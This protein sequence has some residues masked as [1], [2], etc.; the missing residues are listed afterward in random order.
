MTLEN[1]ILNDLAISQ[2]TASALASR[3]EKKISTVETQLIRMEKEGTVRRKPI[4]DG[5]LI[6]WQLA[7]AQ[8]EVI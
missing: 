6:V 7:K 4:C 3:L 8:K 2:T 1:H 5:R